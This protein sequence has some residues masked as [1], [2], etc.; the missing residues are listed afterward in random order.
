MK[1][2]DIHVDQKQ[3]ALNFFNTQG[4][5]Y[6]INPTLKGSLIIEFEFNNELSDIELKMIYKV[7][8]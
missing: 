6:K 4:V 7:L 5:E 3:Q 8:G 2:L 1:T